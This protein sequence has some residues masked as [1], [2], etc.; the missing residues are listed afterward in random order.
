MISLKFIAYFLLPIAIASYYVVNEFFGG[1]RTAIIIIIIVGYF[2][3]RNNFLNFVPKGKIPP[4][5]SYYFGSGM[6]AGYVVLEILVS[7]I[8][9]FLNSI[10]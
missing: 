4:Y 10:G 9:D 3:R 1:Y 7:I 2:I 8:F 6:V 5:Y